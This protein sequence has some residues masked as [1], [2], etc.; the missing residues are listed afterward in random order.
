MTTSKNDPAGNTSCSDGVKQDPFFLERSPSETDEFQDLYPARRGGKYEYT[1]MDNSLG[2][3]EKLGDK[4]LVAHRVTQY[5]EH[6]KLPL[7]RLMVSALKA[8]GCA[9]DLFDRH[10]SIDCCHPGK[11]V[12]H[13]GNYDERNNQIFICANN[14]ARMNA[15]VV[16]SFLLRSL[17]EM[18]DACL[19]KY[20][21]R[22]ARHL[23]CT[24]VRKWNL[25]YCSL[26]ENYAR[27]GGTH[28]IK[29][30]QKN[31]VRDQAI[32]S[33]HHVK[34][35]PMDVAKKAVDEVFDKCY[36]DLEPVGRR[37]WNKDGFR[38]ADRE[39]KLMGYE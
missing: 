10:L 24:E 32:R 15:G 9:A 37:C 28:L 31:C 26:G 14:V 3:A 6:E 35:V 27:P 25:G 19:H 20:N 38:L 4:D 36:S 34:F 11:N 5:L 39:K 30:Q 7:L 29:N 1:L 23:A 18:F 12:E 33:L 13:I 22:D 16:H 8:H 21:Y 17:I 2:F